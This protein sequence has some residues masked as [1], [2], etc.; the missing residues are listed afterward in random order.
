MLVLANLDAHHCSGDIS[1]TCKSV[2]QPLGEKA[3]IKRRVYVDYYFHG[4]RVCKSTYTSAH[5]V[6]LK[7]F[8][9]S[10]SHFDKNGL[11]PRVH[12]N[13]ERLP[14][15]TIPF[16]KTQSIIQFIQHFATVH[17]LP[18]PGRLPGRYSDEK[19]LLLPSH[20]SKRYV[21]RQYCQ[22]CDEKGEMHVGHRKFEDLWGFELLPGVAAMKPATDL[23]HLCQS[24]VVKIVRSANLPDSEKSQ[25]GREAENHLK[26]AIQEGR[27]IPMN[28][29][30]PLRN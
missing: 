24:N 5:A 25:N 11:V 28:V 6:G 12:G 16:A 30:K 26:L 18:L 29:C 7:R 19:A 9:N 10:M 14:S 17:A 1:R 15:N 2:G 13:T 21:H 22:A 4:K 27:C 3:G 23:C 8:K 20:M